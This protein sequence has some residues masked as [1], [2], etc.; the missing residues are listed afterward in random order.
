M[1]TEYSNTQKTMNL[2]RIAETDDM[3]L[4]GGGG[5]RGGGGEGRVG[6]G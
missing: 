2:G 6:E 4:G 3:P 1:T 5:E